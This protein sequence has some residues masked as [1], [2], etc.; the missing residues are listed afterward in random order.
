MPSKRTGTSQVVGSVVTTDVIAAGVA[1]ACYSVFFSTP[2]NMLGWPVA[3]GMLA[4][5]FRWFA[6]TKLGF[7]VVTGAL[8]ACLVVGLLLAP[9]S[10]H[11]HWPFAAIG[12]ASVV[13]MIPGVYAF[14][15][16]SGL[17]QIADTAQATSELVGATIADGM[18]ALEVVLAMS[19]GL[20]VPKMAI[21]Y[22][23]ESANGHERMMPYSR[24]RV[25]SALTATDRSGTSCRRRH[26]ELSAFH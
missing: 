7:G 25:V 1:V 16:M 2:I 20:I 5:G 6:I 11:R 19:L 10:R 23:G 22:L 18:T 12:F 24:E 3:V 21:D 26:R 17:M 8:V 14:R 9:V 15:M 13:S 4:H